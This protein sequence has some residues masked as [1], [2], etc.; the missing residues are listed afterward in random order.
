MGTDWTFRLGARHSAMRGAIGPAAQRGQR[1]KPPHR[2]R[3]PLFAGVVAGRL[4]CQHRSA[5]RAYPANKFL[6]V[7]GVRISE[8]W[9]KFTSSKSAR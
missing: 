7:K 1:A 6:V 2:R 8:T 9:Y 5:T 4:R 3:H